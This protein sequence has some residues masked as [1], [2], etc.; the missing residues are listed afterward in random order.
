MCIRD[1]LYIIAQ[2]GVPRWVYVRL[3][4]IVLML[5]ELIRGMPSVK[6][7]SCNR[8]RRVSHCGGPPSGCEF[9]IVDE[10]QEAVQGN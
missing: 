3:L 4:D 2:H 5:K 7:R 10:D 8:G 6:V 9:I 1:R